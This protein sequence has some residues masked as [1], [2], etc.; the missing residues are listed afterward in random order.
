[1]RWKPGRSPADP[2]WMALEAGSSDGVLLV[3]DFGDLD[4][5]VTC[6]D[7]QGNGSAVYIRA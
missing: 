3:F 7:G 1:M 2:S 4:Q 6:V 5:L